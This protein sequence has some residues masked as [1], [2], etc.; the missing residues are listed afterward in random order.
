MGRRCGKCRSYVVIV[1]PPHVVCEFMTEH[2]ANICVQAKAII[3]V[4]S[5]PDQYD[6]SSILVE[7]KQVRVL[8]WCE[9]CQR[10]NCK[11]VFLHNMLDGWIIGKTV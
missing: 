3:S 11:F 7:A 6:F 8:M 10:P 5:K 1:I 2:A 9:F 4:C